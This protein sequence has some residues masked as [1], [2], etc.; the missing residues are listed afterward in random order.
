MNSLYDP[1][2]TGTGGQ[3]FY[4]DQLSAV[5]NRYRVLRAEFSVNIINVGIEF[6]AVCVLSADNTSGAFSTIT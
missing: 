3:P 4:F 1:D 5:Y 6:P 2:F